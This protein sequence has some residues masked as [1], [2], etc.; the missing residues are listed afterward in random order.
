VERV[1]LLWLG[2]NTTTK[3]AT[4]ATPKKAAPA[5]KKTG[6]TKEKPKGKK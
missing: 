6:A 5:T 1:S 4:K 3:M 2:L